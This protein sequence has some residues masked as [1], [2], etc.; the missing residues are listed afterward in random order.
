MVVLVS[1]A[2]LVVP[3]RLIIGGLREVLSMSPS[4]DDPGAAARLLLTTCRGAIDC[5]SRSY[6][7]RKWVAGWTSRSISSSGLIRRWP[8][9]PIATPYGPICTS[10]LL[11]S[12]YER[13][14]IVAFTTDRRWAE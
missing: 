6:A 13:S 3:F 2:F 4:E 7:P 14:V 11:H 5:K 12:G 8:Q 9:S 10:G 1:V